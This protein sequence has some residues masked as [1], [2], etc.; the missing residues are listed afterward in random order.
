MLLDELEQ[1]EQT[2]K[3]KVLLHGLS[4]RDIEKEEARQEKVRLLAKEAEQ[5]RLAKVKAEEKKRRDEQ[6]ALE[7]K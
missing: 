1:V 6:Y 5:E 7:E 3:N 2:L 4:E